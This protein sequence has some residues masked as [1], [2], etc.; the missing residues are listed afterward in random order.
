MADDQNREEV[1]L[2]VQEPGDVGRIV[3]LLR[4][5]LDSDMTA[6]ALNRFFRLRPVD[7]ADVMAQ[8]PR[9]SPG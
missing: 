2:S 3:A 9:E 7:Q 4:D 8:M 5:L 1:S 6:E